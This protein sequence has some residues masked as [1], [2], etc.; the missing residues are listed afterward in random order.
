MDAP[1]PD[2]A[3]AQRATSRCQRRVQF[4]EILGDDLRV[5]EPGL[6]QCFAV[7]H[8]LLELFRQLH[9]GVD[10][11]DVG[12]LGEAA[13]PLGRKHLIDELVGEIELCSCPSGS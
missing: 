3:A 10:G 1:A 5:D 11:A 4:G 13:L 9:L 7:R 2:Q 6:L 12:A 8:D